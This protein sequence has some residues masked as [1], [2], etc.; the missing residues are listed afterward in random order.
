MLQDGWNIIPM[1][2]I[3]AREFDDA[4][5]SSFGWAIKKINLGFS[6]YSR[7]Q[8]NNIDNND[9]LL[10]AVGYVSQLNLSDYFTMWGLDTSAQAKA[11]VAEAGFKTMPSTFYLPEVENGYCYSLT[12]PSIAI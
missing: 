11:Q 8:A 6:Q 12:H 7:D 10:I 9:F 5:A 2:H 1:L 3:L 4:R